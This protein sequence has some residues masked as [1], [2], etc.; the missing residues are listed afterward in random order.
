MSLRKF[1]NRL[2][3]RF[4]ARRAHTIARTSGKLR[5]TRLEERQLLDAGF[6]IGVGGILQLDGFDAGD[7]L[8]IE[9]SSASG[10]FQFEL[11]HGN[12]FADPVNPD[13]LSGRVQISDGGRTLTIDNST[14][15]LSPITAIDIDAQT[16]QPTHGVVTPLTGELG[17]VTSLNE[18]FVSDL[19]ITGG[20]VVSLAGADFDT[21]SVNGSSLDVIDQDG[22]ELGDVSLTGPLTVMAEGDLTS[23]DGAH[24]DI[25]GHASLTAANISIGDDAADELHFGSLQF[26]STGDV[27]INESESMH[28]IGSNTADT[29]TLHASGDINLDADAAIH[30]EG[31]RVSLQAGTEGS[32]SVSGTIDVSSSTSTGGTVDLF[33]ERVGLFED[34]HLSASGE[35]GGGKILIGGDFQGSNE[36]VPNSIMT[37]VDAGVLIEADAV[38][39]GDGGTV[40]VWSDEVTSFSGQIEARGGADGGDGGFA[41]VSGKEYLE[42][43]GVADLRAVSGADGTL[44]LDPTD[45]T[46]S[47]AVDTGT[48]TFGGGQFADTISTPSN[49]N[50]TTLL[51]QLNLSNVDVNTTSGL[52]GVGNITVVD[53]IA[54]IGAANRTLTFTADGGITVDASISSTVGALSVNFNATTDVDINASVT[55]AGGA[56]DSSGAAFENTGGTIVTSGGSVNLNHTGAMT[57]N[58]AITGASTLT[59][60]GLTVSLGTDLTTAGSQTYTGAVTLSGGDRILTGSTVNTVNTVVGGGNALQITGNAD[61]D[62]AITDVTTFSVSGTTNLGANVTT[63]GTQTYSDD[64]TLTANS[65]I[66]A[67]GTIG[68]TGNVNGPFDL[69]FAGTGGSDVSGTIGAA[70]TG[71]TVTTGALVAG[72]IDIDGNLDA[73]QNVSTDVGDILVAGDIDTE[74]TLISALGINVGGN[75]DLGGNVTTTGEQVYSGAVTQTA[76]VT[77]SGADTDA[78]GEA[79]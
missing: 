58:A 75:S 78:D 1:L 51:T 63:S 16:L 41:E 6:G 61:I 3:K 76:A 70:I 17:F 35:M 23:A 77:Y 56:F 21:L 39:E 32:L 26:N 62:G 30:S 40:I 7:A 69:A 11:E 53:A 9:S 27:G 8:F 79:I 5:V 20:G 22:L 31:G 59:A 72:T 4:L 54:Y 19:V 43:R 45:I 44:L 36:D 38:A 66:T 42:F 64:V 65:I 49:L 60:T 15:Q 13:I 52:A 50:I 74:G 29:A 48:M 28:L 33:G 24:I 34:A 37:F 57:I 18:F 46:V 71:L 47:N 67:I 2:R 14:G 25:A 68:V 12:W 73:D 10:S 55:T